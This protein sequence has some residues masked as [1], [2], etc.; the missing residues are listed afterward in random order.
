V[1]ACAE[2]WL[3]WAVACSL[4]ELLNSMLAGDV[5]VATKHFHVTDS[6]AA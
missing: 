3:D 2:R 1:P 4:D 5:E 6:P